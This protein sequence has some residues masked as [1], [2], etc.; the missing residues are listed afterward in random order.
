M[1]L[2][3]ETK[4]WEHFLSTFVLNALAIATAIFYPNVTSAFGFLGG[5]CGVFVVILFPLWIHVHDSKQ[6]W[7]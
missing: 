2:T 1:G 4:V 6:E 7:Y 3:R 5:T